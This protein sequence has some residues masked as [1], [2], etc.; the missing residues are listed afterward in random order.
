MAL[1][2]CQ[3]QPGPVLLEFGA[4]RQLPAGIVL[5]ET[6]QL[7]GEELPVPFPGA[8]TITAPRPG[9]R[10]GVAYVH[11]DGN[12]RAAVWRSRPADGVLWVRLDGVPV[13]LGCPLLLGVCYLP[14]AGSQ[15]GPRD[16]GRWWAALA[17]DWAEA[18]AVGAPLLAGTSTPALA[19]FRTGLL[20]TR[21]GLLGAAGTPA[22]THT[23]STSLPSATAAA[24]GSATAACRGAPVTWPPALG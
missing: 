23:G 7:V 18:L 8:T 1:H 22:P 24:P 11:L 9:G 6:W 19:S 21:G 14:P 15:R 4:A 17:A 10:G 5:V 16:L 20:T 3:G 13:G 2:N 12:S